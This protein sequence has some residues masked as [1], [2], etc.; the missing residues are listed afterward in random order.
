MIL[1]NSRFC[2]Y[3]SEEGDQKAEGLEILSRRITEGVELA[4]VEQNYQEA[5]LG[6][7]WERR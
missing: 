3:T 7:L 1:L 6:S 4:P 5:V 2:I